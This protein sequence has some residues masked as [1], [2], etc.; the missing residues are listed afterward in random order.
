MQATYK[1]EIENDGT[2]YTITFYK[3]PAGTDGIPSEEALT[4]ERA[5]TIRYRF[6]N[7]VWNKQVEDLFGVNEDSRQWA[8]DEAQK[9][10]DEVFPPSTN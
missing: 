6:E 3:A 7:G 10:I 1:P 8:R 2:L 9:L 5:G 4:S